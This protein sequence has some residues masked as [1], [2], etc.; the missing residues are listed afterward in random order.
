M[1]VERTILHTTR[2][3]TA[4]TT[5]LAGSMLALTGFSPANAAVQ[6]E[7]LSS[8]ETVEVSEN[9]ANLSIDLANENGFE[10]TIENGSVQE[11]EDGS[12]SILN[13]A[14]VESGV[15]QSTITLDDGSTRSVEYEVQ[16][17]DI[18][19]IYSDEVAED[20]N[21]AVSSGATMSSSG[22]DCALALGTAGAGYLGAAG[23]A[24]TAPFTLGGGL[25]VS[26]AALASATAGVN[27]AYQCCG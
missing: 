27:A 21:T 6:D 17:S 16:G 12:L 11:N 13:A 9:Q 26:G 7:N 20:Q 8:A 2:I 15:L 24:L 3:K 22:V 10:A 5:L 19:A 18:K 1:Y 4:I 14:N 23:A 25:V